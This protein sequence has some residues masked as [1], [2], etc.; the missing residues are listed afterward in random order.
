MANL[1]VVAAH[2]LDHS[3]L[4]CPIYTYLSRV[5]AAV[6]QMK[7]A[8]AVQVQSIGNFIATINFTVILDGSRADS[9][10]AFHCNAWPR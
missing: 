10:G 4:G 3:Q 2:N 9:S 5:G 7:L 8:K 1:M 6:V